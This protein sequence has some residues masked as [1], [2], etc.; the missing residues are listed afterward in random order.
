MAD[1]VLVL[2]VL[3]FFGLCVLYIRG[4]ERIIRHDEIGG[5]TVE[6]TRDA[7]EQR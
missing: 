3:A 1:L 2:I 5:T 4:C 6:L 7:A